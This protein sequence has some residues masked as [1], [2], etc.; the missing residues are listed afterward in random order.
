MYND[1]KDGDS[2]NT[3]SVKDMSNTYIEHSIVINN[4]VTTVGNQL[5]SSLCRVF[6]D[7]VKYKWAENDNKS[8][9]PD[10]SINCDIKN[11]RSTNFLGVPRFIMEVL[12][13]STEEYDRSGKKDLYKAVEVPE[14]WLVDWRKKQ[15]EIYVLVTD[16]NTVDGIS[17]KLMSTITEENKTELSLHMFPNVEITFEQLF[18]GID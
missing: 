18:D 7:S 3:V 9:I 16:E 15:V 5:K 14:Y 6:G 1:I 10:V 11:R 2:M 12:S 13:D 17:Y 8:V 4:F